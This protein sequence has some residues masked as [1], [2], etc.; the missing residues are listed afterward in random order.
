MPMNSWPDAKRKLDRMIEVAQREP[1]RTYERNYG[2]K[3]LVILADRPDDEPLYTFAG[4]V[5][6]CKMD[7]IKLVQ[8]WDHPT[9]SVMG[10]N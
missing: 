5:I 2:G 10:D 7:V 1:D 8:T 9:R 4:K 3:H 6:T